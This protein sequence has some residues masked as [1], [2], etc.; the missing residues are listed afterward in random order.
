MTQ[1][2]ARLFYI[3][4]LIALGTGMLALQSG[5][6]PGSGTSLPAVQEPMSQSSHRSA[7]PVADPGSWPVILPTSEGDTLT[8][9]AIVVTGYTSCPRETDST[10]FLTASMTRVRPGCLALSRDLLRTFTKDAPFDFGDCVVLPGVGIFI[11]EDTMNRRWKKR[12][13]IWF[14]SKREARRWGRRKAWMARLP[15]PME[16]GNELFALGPRTD[17]RPWALSD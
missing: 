6:E 14:R 10:P 5:R 17:G 3:P 11:V 9:R 12:A 7:G 8:F 1:L 13:D 4:L 15:R 2:P 16:E